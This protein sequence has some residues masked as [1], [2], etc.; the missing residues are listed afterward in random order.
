MAEEPY[1][2]TRPTWA[3]AYIQQKWSRDRHV[4]KAYK[5]A[6][7]EEERDL[8]GAPSEKVWDAVRT[9]HKRMKTNVAILEDVMQ[10]WGVKFDD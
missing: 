1:P 7:A 2:K 9:A 5:I 6:S 8:W 4:Q 3:L 10:K